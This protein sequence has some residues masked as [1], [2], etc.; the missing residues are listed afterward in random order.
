MGALG[1][2]GCFCLCWRWVSEGCVGVSDEMSKMLLTFQLP[3][4]L[5]GKSSAE[6]GELGKRQTQI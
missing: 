6:F 3:E 1:C 4:N 2:H 5:E